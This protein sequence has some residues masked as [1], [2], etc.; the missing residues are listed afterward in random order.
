MTAAV[1][2]GAGTSTQFG[3]HSEVGKL[4][5]VMIHRPGPRAQAPHPRQPRRA[6]VRRR[7]LGAPR[8]PA[9][10]RV[11]RPAPRPRRRGAVPR[12][13]CSPRPW[14]DRGAARWVL[15]RAVT[16]LHR[17]CRDGRRGPRL[18][19]RGRPG[20]PGRPPHRR[21]DRRARPASSSRARATGRSARGA[22]A[23]RL[24]RRV[25]RWSPTTS[26]CGRCPTATSPA[27]HAPGSTA[28]S[29]ST[30]CT[31]R[32]AGS[33]RSTWRRSTASTRR[34]AT[35]TSSSGTRREQEGESF[36][37]AS[38]EGGDIMPIGNRTVAIGMSERTTGPDDR[39]DR[40]GA[41]R[42]RAPPTGS[43]PRA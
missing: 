25:A 35:P 32:P 5:R 24:A 14:P 6:A 20:H 1:Q 2:P 18:P 43:S 31:G 7:A 28:A 42:R 11:R 12:G 27:T 38:S 29:S 40:A 34:S 8:A 22:I 13:R 33:R 19:G 3:V 26:S 21:A 9:A 36:G 39:E 37:R 17:R 15:D 41:V 4:R 23:K 10:R 16:A 30:R